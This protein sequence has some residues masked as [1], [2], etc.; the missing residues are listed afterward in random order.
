MIKKDLF[1]LGIIILYLSTGIILNSK[2]DIEK[3]IEEV[4]IFFFLLL[5]I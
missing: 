1:D 4:I 2:N 5:I 3:Y